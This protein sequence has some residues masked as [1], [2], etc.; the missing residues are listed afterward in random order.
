MTDDQAIT[1]LV[2]TIIAPLRDIDE[3]LAKAVENANQR[4]DNTNERL[5]LLEALTIAPDESRRP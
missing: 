3:L 2:A 4:I 5:D 1:E